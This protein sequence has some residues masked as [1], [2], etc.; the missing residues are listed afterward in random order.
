MSGYNLI[1]SKSYFTQKKSILG[2]YQA[3]TI[4]W[5]LREANFPQFLIKGIES[6]QTTRLAAQGALAN[7]RQ[8]NLRQIYDHAK[9]AA[10]GFQYSRQGLERGPFLGSWALRA[11]LAWDGLIRAFYTS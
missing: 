9:L 2:S 10:T 1:V 7:H 5:A 6:S 11:T 3:K 4:F 8:L